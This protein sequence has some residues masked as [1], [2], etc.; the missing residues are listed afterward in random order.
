MKETKKR[1]LYE[2][3]NARVKGN[4]IYCI[5]GHPLQNKPGN[6]GHIDVERLANGK[7]LAFGICQD[8]ADFDCNGEPVPPEE[9]G[10]LKNSEAI[11]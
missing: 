6:N 11:V 8:C 1:T 3:S 2:C 10:W 7:R 5:K 9:R 4:A